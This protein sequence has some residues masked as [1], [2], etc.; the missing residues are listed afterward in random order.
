MIVVLDIDK[1][2]IDPGGIEGESCRSFIDSVTADNDVIILASSRSL[3]SMSAGV[4]YALAQ[5][6][7]A[8]CSDGAITAAR[9]CQGGPMVVINVVALDDAPTAVSL[10]NAFAEKSGSCSVFAF[11]GPETSYMVRATLSGEHRDSLERILNG[12]PFGEPVMLEAPECLSV[13]VLGSEAIVENFQYDIP[14]GG[15][16]F[17]RIYEEVR[18]LHDDLWWAEVTSRSADKGAALGWLCAARAALMLGDPRVLFVGDGRNDISIA[19]LADV[20]VCPPWADTAILS[21]A[22]VVGTG[23]DCA[24][25]L[26]DLR[27]RMPFL[28]QQAQ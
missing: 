24:S 26:D 6:T 16:W 14:E 7:F 18:G 11:F 8:I 21:R 28:R 3:P 10:A 9:S 15:D 4:P 27:W 12:R 22:D 2:L 5:A 13:A 19:A 17:L 25:F 1:T 20:V 23:K